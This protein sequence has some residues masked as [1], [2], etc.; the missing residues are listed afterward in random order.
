MGKVL[1][2]IFVL[3]GVKA[4]YRNGELLYR[5][6]EYQE[7]AAAKEDGDLPITRYENREERV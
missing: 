6:G 1:P 2:R 4:V 5:H 3:P 7:D